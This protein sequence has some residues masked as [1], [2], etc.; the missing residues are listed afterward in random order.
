MGVMLPQTKEHQRL[1]ETTGS[2]E[3][4]MKQILSLRPQERISPAYS[5]ISDFQ[6]L[7]L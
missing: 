6:P 7:E 4:N 3:R 2:K 1:L 5:S